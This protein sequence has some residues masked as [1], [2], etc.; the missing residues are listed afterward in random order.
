M[1]RLAA[2]LVAA[3]VVLTGWGIG[4]A[5]LADDDPPPPPSIRT[6]VGVMVDSKDGLTESTI[7]CYRDGRHQTVDGDGTLFMPNLMPHRVFCVIT[8]RSVGQTA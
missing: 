4:S 7:N 3:G 8:I 6:L 2:F 5:A 1:R